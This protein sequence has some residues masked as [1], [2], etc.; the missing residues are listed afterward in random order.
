MIVRN[1]QANTA[2]FS[3]FLEKH[4]F[5]FMTEVERITREEGVAMNDLMFELD[6]FSE[7][8][9]T[10]AP[11]SQGKFKVD[12]AA[13]YTEGSR[14]SKPTHWEKG[15]LA[16]PVDKMMDDVRR[17]RKASLPSGIVRMKGI[18][19]NSD[20]SA[21]GGILPLHEKWSAEALSFF[22]LEGH[23]SGDAFASLES[24]K[25]AVEAD[26]G[27]D[28]KSTHRLFRLLRFLKI[29]DKK[30]KGYYVAQYGEHVMSQVK[31]LILD[32]DEDMLDSSLKLFG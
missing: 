7:D 10:P 32:G 23:H 12:L 20:G 9:K 22:P 13:R 3:G 16:L 26:F 25:K 11:T 31:Q 8:S 18:F 19:R 28:R 6:F 14:P 15:S 24:F 27:G 21:S 17:L 4:Y 2:T 29:S 5:A 30:E 1:E